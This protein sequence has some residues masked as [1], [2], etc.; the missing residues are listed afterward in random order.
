[1]ANKVAKYYD[2]TEVPELL[3]MA[4]GASYMRQVRTGDERYE[5]WQYLSPT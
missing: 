2:D 1:M 4:A 5:V 3:D